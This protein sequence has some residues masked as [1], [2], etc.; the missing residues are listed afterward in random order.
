ML[1][2]IHVWNSKTLKQIKTATDKMQEKYDTFNINYRDDLI[3]TYQKL[4]DQN[5]RWCGNNQHKPKNQQ[6]NF[7]SK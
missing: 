7:A 1:P 2:N 6:E 4:I 5:K 3:V